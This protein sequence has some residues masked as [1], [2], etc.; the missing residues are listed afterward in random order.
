[1]FDPAV[2]S[3]SGDAWAQSVD[4]NATY[5]PVSIA[6]GASGTIQVTITPSGRRHRVVRGF[7]GVDTF[8]P[9]TF[10]GDEVA[11]IPYTYRVR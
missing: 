2:S 8:N 1:M 5:T 3:S 11:V 7:I 10:S 9:A 6:P 4:P